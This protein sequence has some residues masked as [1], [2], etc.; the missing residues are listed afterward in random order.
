MTKEI[1]ELETNPALEQKVVGTTGLKELVVNYIGDKLD[2]EN[3]EVTLEM[4]I[5]TFASEF[6]EF[7]LTVA[8][9]NWMLGYAQGLEDS[10]ANE[11]DTPTEETPPP[12]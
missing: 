11:E 5:N 12:A 6:P 7:L 4:T 1:K 8:E 2:P 3:E 9:E 10:T